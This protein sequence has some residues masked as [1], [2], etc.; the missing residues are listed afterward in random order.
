MLPQTNTFRIAIATFLLAGLFAALAPQHAVAQRDPDRPPIEDMLPETTVAFVQIADFQ[1]MIIK[2]KD[3]AGGALMEDE[4]V[5]PFVERVAEEGRKAYS[6]VEEKVGLSLEEIQSLPSGEI[7]FA[8]VAPR[9]KAPEFFLIAE[10]GEENEAA[11]KALDRL[12]RLMDETENEV[13]KETLESGLEV[14]TFMVDGNETYMVRREGLVVACTSEKEI[15]DFFARWDK[16]EVK[17]VRPLS[18]NRKFITIMNRCA[19]VKEIPADIRF[20]VDPIG[21]AKS[22]GKGNVGIQAGLAFLPTLGLDGLLGAGGTAIWGDEDYEMISHGHLLLANPKKGILKMLSLRPDDYEPEAWVP[23]DTHW[24]T[25]TSWDVPQMYAELTSMVDTFTEEG[26]FEK[27]VQEN[28]NENIEMDLRQDILE[29]LDGRITMASMTEDSNMLNGTAT[30]F[31]LGIKDKDAAREVI[32]K[33]LGTFNDRSEDEN[34][35]LGEMK[36]YRDIEYWC[37]D[38]KGR[39]RR[40]ERRRERMKERAERRGRPNMSTTVRIPNPTF[41]LIGDSLVITDSISAMERVIDTFDG[42]YESLRNNGEFVELAQHMTNLLGTDMPCAISYNQ[43]KH[44]FKLLLDMAGSDSIREFV[45]AAAAGSDE[46]EEDDENMVKAIFGHVKSI[47]DEGEMPSMDD[48]NKYMMPNGW[49]ATSDDT[50]Y[51]LLWFQK[52]FQRE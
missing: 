42:S 34:R 12:R 23:H 24:Y 37:S 7:V 27:L 51:H 15:Q 35:T 14:E 44:Q 2:W 3:G 39:E 19:S 43:P 6:R 31:G 18:S 46:E 30:I 50:G 26:N 28:V 11:D 9:R 48:L 40:S 21:I 20:F 36:K 5:A 13:S 32:E 25:T 45:D 16:E 38:Q 22:A 33:L 8:C 47:L 52:R 1:D 29:L 41:A 49:F 17:K 10:T 4:K